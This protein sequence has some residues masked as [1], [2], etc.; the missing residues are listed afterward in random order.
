MILTISAALN[1][2]RLQ[3]VL[4]F[5]AQGDD[6]A[7]AEIYDGIQPAH[8][9]AATNL[10]VNITLVEPFGTIS[11]G[12][13]AVTPTLEYLI[14]ASGIATWARFY[15]GNGQIAFDCNC[16]AVNGNGVIKVASLDPDIAQLYAGGL[17]RI[18][19]GVLA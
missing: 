14:L 9:G 19:S 7:W 4:N 2:A 12:V 18:A 8:G 16:S 6:N 13:M 1:E 11:N 3:G 5:L 17:T 10:L 15:N